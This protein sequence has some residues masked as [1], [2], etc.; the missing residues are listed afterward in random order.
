LRKVEKKI[1]LMFWYNLLDKNLIWPNFLCKYFL[2]SDTTHPSGSI[3][4]KSR[5][6]RNSCVG[7]KVTVRGPTIYSQKGK[8]NQESCTSNEMTKDTIERWNEITSIFWEA[9][10]RLYRR[11]R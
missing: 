5:K 2:V 9:R 3:Q 4:P 10:S 6:L 8:R 7:S 1:K 11:L